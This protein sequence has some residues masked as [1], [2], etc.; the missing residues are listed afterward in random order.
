MPLRAAALAYPG[1]ESAHSLAVAP[2]DFEEF[3]GVEAGGFGAVKC[4]HAPT[5][6]R[7]GPRPQTIAF[8]GD[9]VVANRGE[10]AA[11]AHW[12][13]NTIPAARQVYDFKRGLERRLDG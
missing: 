9:P 2:K 7:A 6:I 8:R 12:H 3:R 13:E 5:K 1:D 4:F 10:E 11:E